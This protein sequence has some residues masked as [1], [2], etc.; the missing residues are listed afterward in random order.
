MSFAPKHIMVPVAVDPDD[1]FMLAEHAVFAACDIAEKFTSKITLLHLAPVVDP[2]I[3]A[4]LDVSGKIYHS[5]MLV[6]QARIDRGRLKLK[7]L[8]HYAQ[9]RGINVEGRVIDSIERTADVILETA[10]ELNVDLLVLGSHGRSGLSRMLFGS[11]AETVS[12][13]AYMPVLL[14]HP[15]REEEED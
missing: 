3:G 15:I 10:E 9:Q 8:E 7:E 2:S 14:L 4:S 5:F 6:L 13:K 11:V 1:D 12:K